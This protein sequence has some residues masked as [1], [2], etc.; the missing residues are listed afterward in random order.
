VTATRRIADDVTLLPEILHDIGYQTIAQSANHWVSPRYGLGQGFETF[1]LYNTDNELFIYDVMKL[2]MRVAPWEVFGLREHLPSYAYVPISDMVDEAAS[3]LAARDQGRP[4]FLYM[5]PIDPHGPYQPPLRHVRAEAASFD[6]GDYVSYWQ[7]IDG[8]RIG[9]EQLEVT[10][11]LY[12]GEITYSDA[13]IGRLLALLREHDLY[14]DA[15]IVVTSDHGE[16]FMEH[17]L[18]RHSNSLYQQL[19]HVPLIVKYPGQQEGR[20]VDDWVATIDIVP[21]V[22]AMLDVECA[23]CEGRPL[24]EAGSDDSRALVTYLMDFDVIVPVMRAVVANDWKLIEMRGEGAVT[25]E[26]YHVASDARDEH[27]VR[28]AHPDVAAALREL[29]DD[30]EATVGTDHQAETISLQPAELERLRAL[31]YVN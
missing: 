18:W 3:I 20:V 14:D 24:E 15:L 12:D 17:D 5:Q 1:Y 26:L 7:L 11:A 6:R 8:R 31:G 30:Y 25:E 23:D 10:V 16:H 19:V 29:L 21:T 22:T 13:E 2:A 28:E 27:D 9:P 4:L